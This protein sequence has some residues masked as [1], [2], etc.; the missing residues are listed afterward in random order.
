MEDLLD[1]E[2]VE[3][4]WGDDDLCGTSEAS[5]FRISERDG[6]EGNSVKKLGS[7]SA[8]SKVTSHTSRGIKPRVIQAIHDRFDTA[9]RPIHLE[10]APLSGVSSSSS[11]WK[12]SLTYPTKNLRCLAILSEPPSAFASI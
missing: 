12:S 8:R 2:E 6:R 11:Y 10:V 9:K 7:E 3:G 1:G 4:G 5:R